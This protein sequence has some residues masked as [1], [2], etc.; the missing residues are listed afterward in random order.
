MRTAK[1]PESSPV[2]A[3]FSSAIIEGVL[4]ERLGFD[5]VV[6]SDDLGVAASVASYPVAERG[7]LFLQAGGDMVIVADAAAA[8]QMVDATLAV[9]QADAEFAAE[10]ATKVARLLALKQSYG[11]MNC[12]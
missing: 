3:V 8:Q 11:L 12:G 2:A 7:T 6:I 1:R 5:G 10:L 9:A 4:R